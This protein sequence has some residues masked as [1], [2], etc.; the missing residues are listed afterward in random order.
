MKIRCSSLPRVMACPASK[1][2]PDVDID[3]SSELATIGTAVHKVMARI[4]TDNLDGVPDDV[5]DSD[6]KRMAWNGL[7]LWQKF[8]DD[9]KVLYV[10][11]E[12]TSDIIKG[13]PDVVFLANDRLVALD[14][15][16]GYI[17]KS[18][19]EQ[20]KGYLYLADFNAP[21]GTEL[22]GY[23]GV[24]GWLRWRDSYDVAHYDQSDLVDFKRKVEAALQNDTYSPGDHCTYCPLF[25]D[26][27]AL[28]K[29]AGSLIARFTGTEN[30]PSDP[31]LLGNAY[32]AWTQF[33]KFSYQYEKLLKATINTDGMVPLPDGTRLVYEDK[34]QHPIKASDETVNIIMNLVG[35]KVWDAVSISKSAVEKVIKQ[36]VV[37][38][39]GAKMIRNIMAQ[40]DEAGLIEEKTVRQLTVRKES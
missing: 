6:V 29:Q 19:E 16:T 11:S 33:K 2:A 14:W 36:E 24:T 37:K 34:V 17:Q 12:L 35:E 13:H 21:E 20:L 28:T 4:V 40:L 5:K 23:V 8:R 39:Q 22:D 10:E 31:V 7:R 32:E 3:E 26:C 9:A 30:L 15:K 25:H 38:G 27:D 18:Y 1:Q